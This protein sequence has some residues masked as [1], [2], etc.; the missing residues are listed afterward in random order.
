MDG[1]YLIGFLQ[2]RIRMM[3]MPG[4]HFTQTVIDAGQ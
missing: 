1:A 2:L 3:K 4:L